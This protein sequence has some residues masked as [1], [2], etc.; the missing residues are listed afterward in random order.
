VTGPPIAVTDSVFPSLEPAM[1][2]LKRLDPEIRI[3][4]ST[5]EADIL[6]VARDADGVLGREPIN[7]Q[8]VRLAR[9][10]YAPDSDQIPRR[11]EMS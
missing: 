2:A 8:G 4:K 9:V 3:A 10:R 5:S 11:R 6:D 7:L 1:A